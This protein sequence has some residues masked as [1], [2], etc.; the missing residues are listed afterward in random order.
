MLAQFSHYRLHCLTSAFVGRSKLFHEYLPVFIFRHQIS[1]KPD[2]LVAQAR[3]IE[4]A[5]I[6][7]CV[8]SVFFDSDYTAMVLFFHG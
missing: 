6:D 8:I 7:N 4:C 2:S 1:P 3:V 5:I